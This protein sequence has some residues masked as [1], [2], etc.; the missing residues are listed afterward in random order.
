MPP[1]IVD[2]TNWLWSSTNFKGCIQSCFFMLNKLLP[3]TLFCFTCEPK[4]FYWL[5][6]QGLPRSLKILESPGIRAP[7]LVRY[8]RPRPH[9]AGS[10]WKRN[11]IV[12]DT[13]SV[14]TNTLYPHKK[15]HENGTFWKRFPE[16]NNLKTILFCISVDGELFVSVTF[17]IR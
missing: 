4:C 6:F 14:H 3:C 15:I 10:I 16:W 12:T 17:R 5:V 8:L 9:Y 1:A 2:R 7:H 13:P 11:F